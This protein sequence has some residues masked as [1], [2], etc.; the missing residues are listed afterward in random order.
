MQAGL[1]DSI[2]TASSIIHCTRI[3]RPPLPFASNTH[4]SSTYT[5]SPTPV[6]EERL[7]LPS[8]SIF[9]PLIAQNNGPIQVS[10]PRPRMRMLELAWA[11]DAFLTF[12][13]GSVCHD[14]WGP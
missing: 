4:L 14:I 13:S 6:N 9:S 5:L 11:K 3:S 8:S 12:I 2:H 10:P 7:Q 1:L